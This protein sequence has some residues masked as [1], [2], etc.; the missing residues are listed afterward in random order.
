MVCK[1]SLQG[2]RWSRSTSRGDRWRREEM[3]AQGCGSPHCSVEINSKEVCLK[4]G[5]NIRLPLRAHLVQACQ[6]LLPEGSKIMKPKLQAWLSLHACNISWRWALAIRQRW[7]ATSP[8][9]CITALV[10]RLATPSAGH[11]AQQGCYQQQL[12]PPLVR[13]RSWQY[14][15]LPCG[16]AP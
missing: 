11:W 16:P 8:G 4:N 15:Q 7:M 14:L 9:A 1:S 2:M 5:Y 12:Q 3:P 10:L 6:C 13:P